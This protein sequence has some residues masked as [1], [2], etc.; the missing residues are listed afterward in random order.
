MLGRTAPLRMLTVPRQ[1]SS[2]LDCTYCRR[3]FG[4][5]RKMTMDHVLPRSRGGRLRVPVCEECNAYKGNQSL[6]AFV[7]FRLTTGGVRRHRLK[8]KG[9]RYI[10]R[11]IQYRTGKQLTVEEVIGLPAS[12]GRTLLPSRWRR[13]GIPSKKNQPQPM[14]KSRRAL[15]LQGSRGRCLANCNDCPYPDRGICPNTILSKITD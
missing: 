10:C 5:D 1:L 6:E 9:L 7:V 4:S 8:L 2:W 14:V 11:L 13:H 3:P 15:P 12:E